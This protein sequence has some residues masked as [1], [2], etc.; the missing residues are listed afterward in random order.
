[1]LMLWLIS[2]GAQLIIYPLLTLV[3]LS[4]SLQEQSQCGIL[5]LRGS[6]RDWRGGKLSFCLKG[7]D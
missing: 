7:V 2:L 1:M 3:F 5:L 6:I 4:A